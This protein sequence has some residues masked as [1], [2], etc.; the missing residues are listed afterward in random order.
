[1]NKILKTAEA[2]LRD[3]MV[4]MFLLLAARMKFTDPEV[5]AQQYRI[6][7]WQSTV[8]KVVDF[9]TVTLALT[10]VLFLWELHQK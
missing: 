3:P 10:M 9:G 8:Q 7:S 5:L 2:I 1:V 4:L 6:I